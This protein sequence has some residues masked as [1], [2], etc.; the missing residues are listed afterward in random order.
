MSIPVACANS[1]LASK[2]DGVFTLS[3]VT[4]KAIRIQARRA[5]K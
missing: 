2:K 5:A 4:K 3:S 1:P